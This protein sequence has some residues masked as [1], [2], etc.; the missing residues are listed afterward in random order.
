[1]PKTMGKR[2]NNRIIGGAFSSRKAADKA[3][4]AF[5]A[6]GVPEKDIQVSQALSYEKS[7]HAALR[8]GNILVTIHHVRDPASMIEIFDQCEAGYNPN[9]SRNVRQDVV[10][11][12]AGMAAG[13]RRAGCCRRSPGRTCRRGHR[14]RRRSYSRWRH[15]RRG[16]QSRRGPQ[17]IFCLAAA[18]VMALRKC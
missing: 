9:G 1:M 10:G 14:R 17:I 8:R 15:R 2:T 4:A 12:T 6:W 11:M 5:R 13:G 3:I 16:R 18:K 7:T